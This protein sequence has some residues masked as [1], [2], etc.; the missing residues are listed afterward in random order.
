MKDFLF[1]VVD[2]LVTLFFIALVAGFIWL[3]VMNS[4]EDSCASYQTS[5]GAQFTSCD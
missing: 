2:K 5:S 4:G 1:W 3:S